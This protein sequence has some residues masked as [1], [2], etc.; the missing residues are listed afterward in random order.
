MACNLQ[1]HRRLFW[2]CMEP[3]AIEGCFTTG[4]LDFFH[5]VDEYVAWTQL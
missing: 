1:I 2:L 5:P 3:E 4:K